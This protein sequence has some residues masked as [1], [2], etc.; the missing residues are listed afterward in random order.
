[1]MISN[2]IVNSIVIFVILAF[3]VLLPD[4][5]Y[6]QLRYPGFF[7]NINRSDFILLGECVAVSDETIE[8]EYSYLPGEAFSGPRYGTYRVLKYWKEYTGEEHY[9]CDFLSLNQAY[10]PEAH[11]LKPPENGLAP[12]RPEI[13]ALAYFFIKD[14]GI[15]DNNYI[16]YVPIDKDMLDNRGYNEA[17][18]KLIE[19][20]ELDP[21]SRVKSF[22]D[23]IRN[24]NGF[25]IT[26]VK[27]ALYGLPCQY[28]VDHFDE[29]MNSGFDKVSIHTMWAIGKGIDSLDISFLRKIEPF[30]DDTSSAIRRSAFAAIHKAD[31]ELSEKYY[32]SNFDKFKPDIKCSI[33]NLFTGRK[34]S[35]CL[36][37]F[38]K[39]ATDSNLPLRL[40]GIRAMKY[41]QDTKAFQLICEALNDEN[42]EIRTAALTASITHLK[43]ML[44]N[45]VF[46]LLKSEDVNVRS[47]A[48]TVLAELYIRYRREFD[49]Y[50]DVP[51]I[52]Y[53]IAVSK[54]SVRV[55]LRAIHCLRRTNSPLLHDLFRELLHDDVFNIRANIAS[56]IGYRYDARYIPLLEEALARE[57]DES[58][59]FT[60]NEAITRIREN[61]AIL[62]EKFKIEDF[63]NSRGNFQE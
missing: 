60:I 31:C 44:I 58:V 16:G 15:L 56:M 54:D 22:I 48:L 4:I 14:G 20:S 41:C 21:V 8:V 42:P 57:T 52:F 1:M 26:C 61:Q 37:I 3:S 32:L 62:N 46:S 50:S 25:F 27:A 39:A 43:P 29:L 11:F 13:G 28:F 23:I 38:Y 7:N 33:I 40:V 6:A 36:D 59:I 34:D 49:N 55:R 45:P 47:A 19:L 9:I 17:I 51:S 10:K 12:Y 2:R 53:K 35:Q 30:L 63:N 18:T 5:C 24:R